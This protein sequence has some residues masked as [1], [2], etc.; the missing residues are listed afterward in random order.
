MAGVQTVLAVLPVV[1]S[2]SFLFRAIGLSY[3]EVA[4]A[5]LARG[6]AAFA[7]VARF[8]LMLAVVS[9]LGQGLVAF[10]PIADWWLIEL[11]GLRED[12]AAFAYVPLAILAV[13]P[14]LS[15]MQ[16]WQRAMLVQARA[17]RPVTWGTVVEVVGILAGLLLTVAGMDLI[18]ATAA[19]LAFLAGRLAGNIYLVP[20]CRRLLRQ[21]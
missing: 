20:A 11:A 7:P 6:N 21:V 3:Q 10:T 16:A 18:G 14:A 15:V 1:H 2:I 8:A 12:L 4:I 5:L 13:I 17:T 19:A 9:S